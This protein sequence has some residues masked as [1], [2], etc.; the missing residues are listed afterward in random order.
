MYHIPW[1]S[2]FRIGRVFDIVKKNSIDI[3]N[4]HRVMSYMKKEIIEVIEK[5]DFF[6]RRRAVITKRK[7]SKKES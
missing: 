3:N 2:V 5:G 7:T 1:V 6:F 4:F